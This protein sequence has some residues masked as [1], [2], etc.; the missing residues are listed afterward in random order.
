MS[1]TVVAD[2]VRKAINK[3]N[4]V[5]DVTEES[6]R[7]LVGE[8]PLAKEV[9]DRVAGRLDDYRSEIIRVLSDEMRGFFER[10]DLG[11]EIQKAL[12]SMSL[13][14]STEIKFVPK[15]DS[16][17]DSSKVKPVVKSKSR[18]KRKRTQTVRATNKEQS[19]TSVAQCLRLIPWSCLVEVKHSPSWGTMRVYNF[20]KESPYG[21]EATAA[22]LG[23]KGAG[24]VNMCRLGV[25]VPPG[26]I[27]PTSA[28]RDFFKAE[29]KTT[30]QFRDAV[31][32][33]IDALE[34]QTGR[35]QRFG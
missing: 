4:E 21:A 16:A 20:G 7:R 29:C 30:P 10:V 5:V 26:F 35:R 22:E 2:V 31:Y 33:A 28:C 3:G 32:R 34:E 27:I 12:T 1:D 15:G 17:D 6:V 25:P 11:A 13:E 14:I 24:L 23:G 8:L 18:V 9:A 19:K